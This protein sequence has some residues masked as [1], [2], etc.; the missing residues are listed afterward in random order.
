MAWTMWKKNAVLGIDI[1]SRNINVVLTQIDASNKI[2]VKNIGAALT[3][4]CQ[5]GK[6]ASSE[7]LKQAVSGAVKK[8]AQSTD[9]DLKAFVNIP[10]FQTKSIVTSATIDIRSYNPISSQVKLMCLNQ[11]KNSIRS[12]THTI[13]HVIPTGFWI[14][15][16]YILDPIGKKGKVL[17]GQVLVILCETELLRQLWAIYTDLKI[18]VLGFVY[19][20]VALKELLLLDGYR[21]QNILII[22]CWLR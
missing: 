12:N 6:I 5:R 17:K 15:G 10:L 2:Q 20:S 19:D 7:K 4:G 18:N 13:V 9:K 16:Q 8:V 3:E 21:E 1:G 11:A 14:D 22:D